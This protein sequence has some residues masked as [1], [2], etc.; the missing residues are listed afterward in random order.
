VLLSRLRIRGRLAL[1]AIVPLLATVP[2]T[3]YTALQLARKVSGVYLSYG[4]RPSSSGLKRAGSRA[5]RSN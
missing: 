1:L 4:V 3:A 2:L 5:R